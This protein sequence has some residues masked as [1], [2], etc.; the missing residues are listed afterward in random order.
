MNPSLI[1]VNAVS[2]IKGDLLKKY[3][4]HRIE[5]NINKNKID[6]FFDNFTI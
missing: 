2:V 5:K 1:I 3:N 6:I 4:I